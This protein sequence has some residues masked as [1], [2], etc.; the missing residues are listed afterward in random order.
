MKR[1]YI[2]IVFLT[3]LVSGLSA[4]NAVVS[5]GGDFSG[6]NSSI[7]YS[8]GQVG[9]NAYD[10]SIQFNE[11]VQ[12]PYEIYDVTEEA[13]ALQDGNSDLRGTTDMEEIVRSISLSAYPN[14]TDDFLNLVVDGDDLGAMKCTVYDVS[15]RQ[16]SE[17]SIFVGE[18]RLDMG[19]L[20][21]A[22]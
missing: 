16:I 6:T 20:P 17:R 5:S 4:Q 19:G 7:S 11:G 8:V 22:T 15:G 18:T 2:L 12:Q 9:Y 14:P 10:G 13:V 21:P 3:L 1:F